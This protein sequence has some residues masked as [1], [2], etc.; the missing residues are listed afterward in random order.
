MQNAALALAVTF[1]AALRASDE[2][3]GGASSPEGRARALLD[4]WTMLVSVSALAPVG[5]ALVL[6]PRSPASAFG[7]LLVCAGLYL[8]I[9]VSRSV[10]W[11]QTL[12]TTSRARSPGALRYREGI[13]ALATDVTRAWARVTLVLVAICVPLEVLLL[14]AAAAMVPDGGGFT[15]LVVLVEFGWVQI[16]ILLF[17]VLVLSVTLPLGLPTFPP[18]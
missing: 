1:I 3:A 9:G 16:P 4:P 6:A 5:W 8:L 18:P 10:A 2:R 15:L 17:G 12:A 13:A 11:G 14:G 7:L